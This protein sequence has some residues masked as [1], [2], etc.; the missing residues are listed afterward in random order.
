MRVFVSLLLL[1]Q[2]ICSAPQR[3]HAQKV[4]DSEHRGLHVMVA[5]GWGGGPTSSGLLHSMEIGHT[6]NSGLALVYNHVFVWSDGLGKPAPNDAS[7]ADFSDLFGGHF[8]VL[9]VPLFSNDIVGK[10]GAGL[11]ENVDLSDGFR[12]RFGVGWTYGIDLHLPL[13]RSSGLLLTLLGVHAVTV[14]RGHQVAFAAG[15][16]YCW[17]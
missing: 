6:F 14:D 3:A 15:L 8:A 7:Y 5:F 11:G 2:V 1:L 16:G 9:K 10:I 17:F 4:D 12:P 13:T